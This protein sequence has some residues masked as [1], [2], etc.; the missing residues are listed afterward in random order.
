MFHSNNILSLF[1]W[2]FCY[3]F[4]LKFVMNK[5]IKLSRNAVSFCHSIL[6]IILSLGFYHDIL[7]ITW[8]KYLSAGYFIYDTIHTKRK[9]IMDFGFICHHIICIISLQYFESD[10][11]QS[12]FVDIFFYSEISNVLMYLVYHQLH[13][14][15]KHLF[16]LQFFQ[17]LI[18][19]YIRVYVLFIIGINLSY[20]KNVS[21]FSLGLWLVYTL[22]LIWGLKLCQ[23]FANNVSGSFQLYF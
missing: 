23:Q 7:D 2:E 14:T 15:H 6:V 12:Y 19:L 10:V 3:Y 11:Y 21:Y 1:L 17:T 20:D 9:T 13:T 4:I 22:G 5:N 16:I 8:L 18:F